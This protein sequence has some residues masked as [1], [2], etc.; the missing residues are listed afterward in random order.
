MTTDEIQSWKAAKMPR[1]PRREVP[2]SITLL[3][4]MEKVVCATSNPFAR[5]ISLLCW[6]CSVTLMR[7]E[8]MTITHLLYEGDNASLWHCLLGKNSGEKHGS[9]AHRPWERSGFPVII[10]Y[11]GIAKESMKEPLLNDFKRVWSDEEP[12]SSQ[13][14]AR[15]FGP[16]GDIQKAAHWL[17]PR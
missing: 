4:G 13:Y 12:G 10:P 1:E 3:V 6:M 2:T 15:G 5:R 8:H 16:G 7:W 14:L 17:P 11:Q 9:A